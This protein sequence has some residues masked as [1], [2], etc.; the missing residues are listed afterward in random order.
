MPSTT[1]EARRGLRD[2]AWG[3]A[4]LLVA[5]L[6]AAAVVARSC[7]SRDTPV[8]KED[9]VAIARKEVDYRPTRVMTRFVPRGFQSRPAWAVSLGIPDSAGGFSR[10]AVV[11]VDAKTGQVVEIRK[12]R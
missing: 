6:L 4:A 12:Q 11:V 7:G 2:S 10:L 5:V 9:A 1:A 8:S 3:R